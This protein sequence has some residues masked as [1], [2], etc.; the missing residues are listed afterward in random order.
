MEGMKTDERLL[1]KFANEAD[2]ARRKRSSRS[3]GRNRGRIFESWSFG[4][5]WR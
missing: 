5:V 1:A 2:E 3:G 4:I